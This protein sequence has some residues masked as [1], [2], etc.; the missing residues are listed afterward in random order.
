MNK[1]ILALALSVALSACGSG[2]GSS[3][4]SSST[5]PIS[6]II[7]A[8]QANTSPDTAYALL[9]GVINR[10]NTWVYSGDALWHEVDNGSW[11]V[12]F[13]P[14]TGPVE[15]TAFVHIRGGL[16]SCHPRIYNKLRIVRVLPS[17]SDQIMVDSESLIEMTSG[18]I[19]YFD[20][21]RTITALDTSPVWGQQNVYAIEMIAGDGLHT[22]ISH[23]SNFRAKAF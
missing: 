4:S 15:L 7:P 10:G 23:G 13:T 2:G 22:E 11:R 6:S 12:S 21:S 8:A 16:G 1:N 17:Y 5:N 18:C 14:T 19:A 3:G 20:A 9:G